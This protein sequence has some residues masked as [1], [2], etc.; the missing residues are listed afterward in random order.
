MAEQ[1]RL[2]N[3]QFVGINGVF[4]FTFGTIAVFY[5]LFNYLQS[6]GIPEETAGLLVGVYSLTGMALYM[7]VI[8]CMNARRA[9]LSMLAGLIILGLSTLA[10]P[11]ALSW[12]AVLLLRMLNGAGAFLVM[13]AGLTLMVEVIP[14]HK[15]GQAFALHSVNILIPYALVPTLMDWLEPLFAS[16]AHGYAAIAGTLVPA[17]GLV[18][19]IRRRRQSGPADTAPGPTIFG[20]R[21]NLTR[22][23]VITLLLL[24]TVYFIN[25]AGLFFLFKGFALQIGLDNVGR[26]FGIQML[27]MA[28]IRLVAGSLFDRLNKAYIVAVSFTILA[29]GHMGMRWFPLPQAMPVMAVV[30]GLGMGIGFPPL[31]ALMFHISAPRFR[32]LNANLMMLAVHAGHFMGPALGGWLVARTGYGGY[33]GMEVILNLVAAGVILSLARAAR[34][35][36][37]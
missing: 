37:D 23:P 14:E 11:W 32:A 13:A 20:A 34:P 5:N 22:L 2:L 33:F 36:G 21:D 16:A 17:L 9:P 28:L 15:S 29:A 27:L 6:L 8:P 18:L 25:W 1:K 7:V 12:Q 26:F 19:V 30:F 3:F 35:K 24:N 31:N 4:F 10:Y